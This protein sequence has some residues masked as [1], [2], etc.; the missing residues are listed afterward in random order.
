[1]LGVQFVSLA[2]LTLQAKRYFEELF[3]LGT[4]TRRLMSD[5][6]DLQP[7]SHSPRRAHEQG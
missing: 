6:P 7:V 2:I 4:S 1:M 5:E 3:H